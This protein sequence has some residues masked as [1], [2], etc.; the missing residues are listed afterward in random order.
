MSVVDLTAVKNHLK[1]ENSGLDEVLPA[2]IE[3]AQQAIEQRVGPLGSTD[4]TEVVT[5]GAS[6]ALLLATMPVLTVTSVTPLGSF[7]TTTPAVD[8]VA[9]ILSWPNGGGPI[10]G[11]SCTVVYQAGRDPLP[12]A[13]RLAVLEMVRHLLRSYRGAKPSGGQQAAAATPSTSL[14]STVTLLLTGYSTPGI[15]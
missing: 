8:Q 13:L 6:G 2:Y 11:S 4:V 3:A 10:A 14:P 9:G 15:A 1:I 12:N 7:A 5:A